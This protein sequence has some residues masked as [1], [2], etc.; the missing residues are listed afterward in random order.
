MTTPPDNGH[1]PA[2]LSELTAT[3]AL[4]DRLGA[5]NAS[6]DD[7]R[8]PTAAVLIELVSMIDQAQEP[9]V[10]A[11]RLIEVL[12]GRPLYV[13]GADAAAESPLMIDLTDGAREASQYPDIQP[14]APQIAR[15][16]QVAGAAAG[17]ESDEPDQV[18]A[19]IAAD[20]AEPLVPVSKLPVAGVIP[21][22][23]TAAAE[24]GARRRWDRVLSHASLPAA[25]VV[26]LLAIGGGVSA[27]VTGNPMAPVEG[28]TRVMTQ[29]PGVNDSLEKV[30]TEIYAARQAVYD[31]NVNDANMHLKNARDHLSEVPDADKPELNEEIEEVATLVVPTTASPTPPGEPGTGVPVG[32][33]PAPG[34][35]ATTAPVTPEPS[36]TAEP[37]ASV[38]PP[39]D[40]EPTSEPVPSN[41]DPST[42]APVNTTQGP[43]V[44]VTPAAS[45]SSP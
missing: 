30:K 23:F 17:T 4:L 22:R 6:A 11:V 19:R 34:T 16:G 10:H 45:A 24:S 12:A 15:T 20:P 3:D 25:S 38:S 26:L 36:A 37:S 42:P 13:T 41:D 1:E 5:R 7:L 14:D 21:I 32:T 28:I 44:V 39:P 2:D 33:D 40:S 43:A 18:A 31:N 27:A 8:D 29:L 9:D 35:G